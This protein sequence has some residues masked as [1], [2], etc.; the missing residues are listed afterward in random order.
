[1]RK[2]TVTSRFG[3]K[4]MVKNVFAETEGLQRE[5][6]HNSRAR[7]AKQNPGGSL[8][9]KPLKQNKLVTISRRIEEVW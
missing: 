2:V 5:W 4:F 8:E 7:N 6:K 9:A 1:M 3:G